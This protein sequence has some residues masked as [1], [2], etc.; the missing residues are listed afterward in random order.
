LQKLL[1]VTRK[2]GEKSLFKRLF[3]EKEKNMDDLLAN[4][5]CHRCEKRADCYPVVSKDDFNRTTIRVLCETCRN[6]VVD[7]QAIQE[8]LGNIQ[9]W[10]R[11]LIQ[12]NKPYGD[13]AGAARAYLYE[14]LRLVSVSYV[15]QPVQ[16]IIQE[17]L[18]LDDRI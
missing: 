4:T 17:I 16:A 18:L 9:R 12:S 3:S 13:K 7:L 6:A 1:N 10:Y 14:V 11:K 2:D 15:P 8:K 5:F